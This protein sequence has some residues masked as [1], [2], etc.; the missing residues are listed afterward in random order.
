MKESTPGD[1]IV[2]F[3]LL[4][5]REAA[6]QRRPGYVETC[7][8]N[9]IEV[10]PYAVRMRASTWQRIREEFGA[11]R[12]PVLQYGPPPRGLG[13]FVHLAALPVARILDRL[14]GTSLASCR[15]CARRRAALNRAWQRLAGWFSRARERD[16]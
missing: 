14:L 7:L 9:A 3:S 2:A 6:K 1:P 4:D 16:L 11:G 12:A 15:A 8:A 13:D 5:L 10:E